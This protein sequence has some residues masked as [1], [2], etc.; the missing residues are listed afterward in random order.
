MVQV[1]RI[2]FHYF[3]YGRAAPIAIPGLAMLWISASENDMA[4]KQAASILRS[5]AENPPEWV[6]LLHGFRWTD[7]A[8]LH[9]TSGRTVG[10]TGTRGGSM[11]PI[12][13]RMPRLRSTL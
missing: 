5:Q 13:F 1:S 10:G 9:A 7:K 6:A 2:G 4:L 12:G 3:M 11:C 8:N